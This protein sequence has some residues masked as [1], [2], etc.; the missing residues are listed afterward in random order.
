MIDCAWKETRPGRWERPQS[1][2]EKINILTRNVP[3]AIGRD[4]WAKNAV[5]KLKF[6]PSIKDPAAHLEIAWKQVRYN[7]PEIAAFPHNG[8]YVYRI[9]DANS[10]ALWVSATFSVIEGKTVDELLGRIPRNEQMMCYF[11]R[12][13]SEVMIWSPHYRVDARGAIF[14]LNHL[15]ESLANMNP[16]LVFGGCA[17]NLTPSMESTLRIKHVKTPAI[18]A[19]AE[20]RLAALE[21]HKPALELKPKVKAPKPGYTQRHFIKLS[22]RDTKAITDYCDTAALGLHVTLHAALISAVVKL[23]PANEARSF[24]A[25]F[26]YNLRTLIPKGEAPENSPTSY[27]SVIT[28]EVTVSPQTDFHSYY[29]QLAPVYA[30]GYAPYLESSPYYHKLLEDRLTAPELGKNGETDGQLQPRFAFL[31]TIDDKIC[32]NVGDGLVTVDDFWLGAETLTL[33]MMVHT[34]VWD[35]QLV[36]SVCYNQNYWDKETAGKL[37]NAMQDTLIDVAL[38]K[39]TKSVR[40]E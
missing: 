24:M 11:L 39:S 16:D 10:I 26:H 15:V 13:T 19:Q 33:R 38:A 5:A 1:Y 29:S 28:T 32:R 40:I 36:L 14:C 3:N 23:A 17:K 8:N 34:W 20:S 9:G 31:G 12:D 37:L 22:K 4:N 6:H 21:P 30:T 2:L 18:E 27:T 7:H 35:G 25:S